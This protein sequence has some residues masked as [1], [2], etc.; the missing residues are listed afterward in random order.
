[1]CAPI[2]ERPGEGGTLASRLAGDGPWINMKDELVA[3]TRAQLVSGTWSEAARARRRSTASNIRKWMLS[4][5]QMP[6]V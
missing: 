3:Q 2:G 1:M 4:R 5:R 6:R